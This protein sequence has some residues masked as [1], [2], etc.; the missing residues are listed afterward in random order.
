MLL[1]EYNGFKPLIT[2]GRN[3]AFMCEGVIQRAN[4]KN[5]NGRIYPMSVLQKVVREYIAGPIKENRAYGELD[6][7]D[8]PIVELK[9]T[10]HIIKELWWEGED[11]K[12]KIEILDTPFGN[13]VKSILKRGYTIGISS[14]GTGSVK[15]L[16]ENTVEV[17]DDF[18]LVCWDFVSNP[19]THGA[20][21]QAVQLNEGKIYN[22]YEKYKKVDSIMNELL[23]I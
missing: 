16:D 19:S 10:S 13:I 8:S 7:P 23:R 3:G 9:N 1:V 15:Q 22:E 11:L 18:E 5:Q 4:K 14:R 21:V 6:H 2:E 17:Q 20:Y 12:G